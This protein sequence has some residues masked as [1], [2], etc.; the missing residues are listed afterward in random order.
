[1]QFV[2]DKCICSSRHRVVGCPAYATGECYWH[3]QNASDDSNDYYWSC[4]TKRRKNKG[5]D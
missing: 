4:G 2:S 1:M 5:D 3:P